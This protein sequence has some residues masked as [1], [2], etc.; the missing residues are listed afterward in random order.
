[1]IVGVMIRV[2][3]RSVLF[4]QSTI[5][6]SSLSTGLTYPGLFEERGP[7]VAGSSGFGLGV[8]G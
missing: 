3:M 6:P 8:S 1:M 7:G 5:G 2:F 4:S